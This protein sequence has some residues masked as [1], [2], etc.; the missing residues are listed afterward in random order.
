MPC[1]ADGRGRHSQMATFMPHILRESKIR[2]RNITAGQ[3][4]PDVVSSPPKSTGQKRYIMAKDKPPPIS[5]AT[6]PKITTRCKSPPRKRSSISST[7]TAHETFNQ[8]F[9]NTVKTKKRKI[10]Q[11]R[12]L[13]YRYSKW[14]R[15]TYNCKFALV[16][17]ATNRVLTLN[18]LQELDEPLSTQCIFTFR[19][20]PSSNSSSG[21]I[22]AGEAFWMQIEQSALPGLPA[23]RAKYEKPTSRQRMLQQSIDSYL[24]TSQHFAGCS[25]HVEVFK[26]VP[27]EDQVDAL[28]DTPT[29]K[30]RQHATLKRNHIDPH[31][32]AFRLSALP[33]RILSSAHFTAEQRNSND[34]LE[35][36][37]EQNGVALT[38]GKWEMHQVHE[39]TAHASPS[40][41][42][43]KVLNNYSRVRLFQNNLVLA[44]DP[45]SQ[46]P[47]LWDP[48]TKPK[49]P[50]QNTMWKICL[51]KS[52]NVVLKRQAVGSAIM[53]KAA[54]QMTV[55]QKKG[56]ERTPWSNI[57][58]SILLRNEQAQER[59]LNVEKQK[60][61]D[62]RSYYEQ[63]FA[64]VADTKKEAMKSPSKTRPLRKTLVQ[65]SK[66]YK[67]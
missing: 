53:A 40:L 33:T 31:M 52:V 59:I 2:L 47:I 16:N 64:K 62:Q 34:A 67:I 38:M 28:A 14:D 4:L 8:V 26:K 29:W 6:L 57:G 66:K 49:L 55:V 45:A 48:S 5:I 60:E 58:Q 41:K 36:F 21:P 15:I 19:D 12:D 3:R 17:C 54:L 44:I 20:S 32:D 37:K 22:H 30:V 46:V 10:L 51:V 9:R 7:A 18:S 43:P 50:T 13:L 42:G 61:S 24:Y 23:Y 11:F 56:D 25:N 63:L 1:E 27:I 39:E 35:W 65:S